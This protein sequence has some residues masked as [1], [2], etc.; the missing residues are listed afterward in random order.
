MGNIGTQS[1]RSGLTLHFKQ[2][3]VDVERVS[4][5]NAQNGNLSAKVVIDSKDKTALESEYFEWPER[6][7]CRRW[8]RS[9]RDTGKQRRSD[10]ESDETRETSYGRDRPVYDNNYS[11]QQ[12]E[13]DNY[14]SRDRDRDLYERDY[15]RDYEYGHS[16]NID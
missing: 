5:F 13:T 9:T 4:F 7:Y 10:Y 12:N 3:G 16:Y 1:T 2:Q 6:M 11:E 15:D 8:S 14:R